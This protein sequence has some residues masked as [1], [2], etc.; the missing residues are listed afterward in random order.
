MQTLYNGARNKTTKEIVLPSNAS[1]N[2]LYECPDCLS[3]VI[4]ADGLKNCPH[5]RHKSSTACDHYSKECFDHINGKLKLCDFLACDENT[6]K[7]NRLCVCCENFFDVA[8]F[9]KKSVETVECEY[10]FQHKGTNRRADV[11]L[12]NKQEEEIVAIFEILVTSKT[13]VYARPEPWF[14]FVAKDVL[15]ALDQSSSEITLTCVRDTFLPR[16]SSDPSKC[17][18]CQ[19]TQIGKI[20]FNQRGAGCGKTYESIQLLQDER[21]IRKTTFVYLTKMKSATQVIKTELEE[22]FARGQFPTYTMTPSSVDGARQYVTKIDSTDGARSID[23]IIGTID[24]FVFALRTKQH[25]GNDMFVKILHDIANGDVN[26]EHGGKMKYARQNVV[27]SQKCLVV[28]DEA[29]DLEALY[30]QSFHEIMQRTNIDIWVIGDLL[31]SILSEENLFKYL[32]SEAHLYNIV[33]DDGAKNVCLR[34]HNK[35]LMRL[36]NDTVRFDAFGLPCIEDICTNPVC[37]HIHDYNDAVH[38]DYAMPDIFISKESEA[39]AYIETITTDM[40]RKVREHGY[41]PNNFC[42]IFPVV[43][44]SNQFIVDLKSHLT[45]FWDD[46][47]GDKETYTE[48]FLA[49]MLKNKEYWN[50]KL[51]IRENDTEEQNY[52]FHHTAQNNGSINLAESIH[53]T[54][55]MSIHASKGQGCECVYFLGVCDETMNCFCD[56]I[57]GSLVFESL[58]HVGLTRAKKYL[59]VGISNNQKEGEIYKRF[60]GYAVPRDKKINFNFKIKSKNLVRDHKE[61][62]NPLMKILHDELPVVYDED[63]NEPFTFKKMYVNESSS[64]T[65]LDYSHHTIRFSVMQSRISLLFYI[66]FEKREA[67]TCKSFLD[68]RECNLIKTEKNKYSTAMKTLD[69]AINA[70]NNKPKNVPIMTSGFKCKQYQSMSRD[71][72]ALANG[73]QRKMRMFKKDV[74]EEVKEFTVFECLMHHHLLNMVW[75]PYTQCLHIIDIY[76][77]LMSQKTTLIQGCIDNHYEALEN[78]DKIMQQFAKQPVE[79]YTMKDLNFKTKHSVFLKNDDEDVSIN[80]QSEMDYYASRDGFAVCVYVSPQLNAMNYEE[81]LLKIMLQEYFLKKKAND[82]TYKVFSYI[83][84]FDYPEPILV[85]FNQNSHDVMTDYV[86]Q[87]LY[88]FYEE[89]NEQRFFGFC[90]LYNNE[91]D[92][93]RGKSFQELE[94][95]IKVKEKQT[96]SPLPDYLRSYFKEK[97]KKGYIPSKAV[98][99]EPLNDRIRE[100]IDEMFS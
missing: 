73:V 48:A 85:G 15:L 71:V 11:A 95:I 47:F 6:L 84:T 92:G 4:F 97:G 99:L 23:V 58:L 12:L 29:Q 39:D 25:D 33:S 67:G 72:V 82:E 38:V 32:R 96:A 76:R 90:K 49:N 77:L 93:N 43:S 45:D 94:D 24:S 9:N 53:C 42:F 64:E 21:F 55:I 81:L 5:F 78:I 69:K 31:Q 50:S 22:Q 18:S 87:Y 63:T 16:K 14:E 35:D 37:G 13:T 52:V 26:V 57:E 40:K 2:D 46:M 74:N 7:I 62:G 10:G 66:H 100:I 83:L 51:V 27:L 54:R 79:G 65:T 86:K 75:K 36:V 28:I 17:Q 19:P 98:D 3:P 91:I 80:I 61:N 8:Q 30:I 70:R 60:S 34:F 44:D 68:V 89:Y 20:Y 1:K 56:K 59:W 41:L 88:R